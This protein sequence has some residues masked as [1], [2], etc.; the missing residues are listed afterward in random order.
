MNVRAQYSLCE[1]V[2]KHPC[3]L[4]KKK[5]WKNEPKTQHCFIDRQNSLVQ[6]GEKYLFSGREGKKNGGQRGRTCRFIVPL[7]IERGRF[8]LDALAGQLRHC[9]PGDN[10]FYK[11]HSNSSKVTTCGIGGEGDERSRGHGD[12]SHTC[13][14]QAASTSTSLFNT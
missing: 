7:F 10:G 2:Q 9:A 11:V 6:T 4:R 13:D 5:N 3:S 8:H 14:R 1:G 12:A